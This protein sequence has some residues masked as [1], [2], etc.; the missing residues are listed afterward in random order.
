METYNNEKITKTNKIKKII[1]LIIALI[2]SASTI[3]LASGTDK[4]C[5]TPTDEQFLELRA[6]KITDVDGQNKQVTMELWGNNIAFQ[7][8]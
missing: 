5:L 7:R 2:L 1:I 8:F 4:N 6:T 3:I